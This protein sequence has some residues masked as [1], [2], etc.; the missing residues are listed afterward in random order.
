VT[1]RFKLPPGDVP[2]AVAAR[3]M[4]MTLEAFTVALPE[5]LGRGFPPA[6]PTT[7]NYAIEA[8]EAW[9]IQF[10]K[11]VLGRLRAEAFKTKPDVEGRGF[12][13]FLH[14]GE[15]IKIGRALD[16]FARRAALQHGSPVKL[17]LWCVVP[18]GAD[19]E[20]TLHQHFAEERRHGEWFAISARLFNYIKQAMEVGFAPD[21]GFSE[22]GAPITG[23][24]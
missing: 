9:Q 17:D 6:D 23:P 3:R 5:L 16:P 15:L 10:S 12:V 11:S 2:P 22:A 21:M 4:G 18:G 1:M 8:I 20:G 19:L 14:G 7:G 13:Y 24:P